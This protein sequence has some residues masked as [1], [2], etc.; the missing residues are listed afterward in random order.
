MRTRILTLAFVL[1]FPIAARAAPID[2]LGTKVTPTSLS[3]FGSMTGLLDKNREH[4]LGTIV[5]P[6]QIGYWSIYLKVE[7]FNE[8]EDFVL[9]F[10]VI[11]HSSPPGHVDGVSDITISALLDAGLEVN[12]TAT[13]T[14]GPL[15]ADHGDHSDLYVVTASASVLTVGLTKNITGYEFTIDVAHCSSPCAEEPPL[16]TPIVFPVTTTVVPEP[17]SIA[18]LGAGLVALALRR[19]GG[20]GHGS[21]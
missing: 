15:F 5:A 14:Q 4:T 10:A 1:L 2:I 17:A 20:R 13:T 19:R 7:E 8:D 3:I 21:P 11:K 6:Y 12:G 9:I 18:L 16:E